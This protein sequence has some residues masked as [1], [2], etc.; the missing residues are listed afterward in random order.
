[1]GVL[2]LFGFVYLRILDPNVVQT[3]RNQAFDLYQQIKPRSYEPVPVTIVDIDDR[4]LEQVGQWPWPRTE[5][6]DLVTKMH[7]AGA[8]AVA[9][10]IVFSEPD[11]LSPPAIA[12]AN[13]DLPKEIRDALAA[14]PDSDTVLADA[15]ANARVIMGQTAVRNADMNRDEAVD[16]GYAPAATIG[17]DPGPF[18]LAFPDLIQNRPELEKS[19]LGHGVFN[20]RPDPDGI[21][22][23]VPIVLSVQDRLRMGLAPELIRVATG[24]DAF[25]IRTG[26]AGIE[27]VVLGRQKIATARDGTIH[28][29]LTPPRRA[30][31]VSAASVLDGSMPEGR[32]NGQLVLVGT[33]A[34]GLE[35]F[36]PTPL[37][38]SMAGVEIHAQAMENLITSTALSRSVS[39]D[40]YEVGAV[41]ALGTLVILL[42]PSLGALITILVTAT[43]LASYV[44]YSYHLFSANRVLL[45]PAF[46]A[47]A[48]LILV[49]QMAAANYL[50]EERQKRQIRGAFGQYV[51][52][53]LV[54]QLA[55]APEKLTLGGETRDLTILFSDVRGFTAL[56]ESFKD[57]PQGLTLL[58]NRFLTV[59]S[60]AILGEKG[61]IDKFMGDAVMAFWNAPL[62]HDSHALAGCRA[63][64]GMIRDVDALNSKRRADASDPDTFLP[65]TVGVG[66]NT[67]PCVVG[68][69]GSNTRFDYTA[70]GDS[71]NLAS[72]LEGQSKP[73][74]VPIVLGQSTAEAVGET[75][76][77]VEFDLIRVKG[78]RQPAQIYALLGEENM[79]S[80][81]AFQSLALQMHSLMQSYRGQDWDAAGQALTEIE[82]LCAAEGYPLSGVTALYRTR[83]SEYR[84]SPPGEAWDGV[85]SAMTK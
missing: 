68:N 72:R 29:Y 37:G 41:L 80:S 16:I 22:R 63:A 12:A 66:L 57:D 42:V 20:V 59:L 30:R 81:P 35:D 6:A 64:L 69:M 8:I 28:T 24:G 49:I 32:L 76:A 14:M 60:N 36:R 10:D 58:M 56:S 53:D 45:D 50:R 84:T 9:F 83:I 78:K 55:D 23:R 15:M 26:P 3:I 62:P 65:I 13:V 77:L 73:Y 74:G 17:A 67:G 61:T 11:R 52:P 82:T 31:F 85:Y 43:L 4:S 21:Y 2:L 51:S 40:L 18:I 46:P 70:L 19:A 39:A 44:G 48:T 7:R 34:I 25:A 33:S 79:R 47:L 5:I 54:A 71:V 38:V 75:L 1:M 27:H